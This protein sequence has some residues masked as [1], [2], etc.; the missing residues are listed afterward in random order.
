VSVSFLKHYNF[1]LT[2]SLILRSISGTG[3]LDSVIIFDILEHPEIVNRILD[4]NKS[5]E[6]TSATAFGNLF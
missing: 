4:L 1:S 2:F 3:K 5:T 6:S